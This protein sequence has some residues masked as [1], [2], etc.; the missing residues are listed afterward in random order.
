MDPSRSHRL[1]VINKSEGPG[2]YNTNSNICILCFYLLFIKFLINTID[3]QELPGV[4]IGSSR[5]IS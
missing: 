4:E 3:K 2:Q 1:Y 5:L